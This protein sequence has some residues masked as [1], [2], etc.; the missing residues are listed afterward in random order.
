M[1]NIVI[2]MVVG[3]VLGLVL[4]ATVIAP[5][6]EQQQAATAESE[7]PPAEPRDAAAEA[8]RRLLTNP[9]SEPAVRL[10]MASAFA[11]GTPIIGTLAKRVETETWRISGGDVEITFHEPGALVPVREMFNAVAAGSVDAAFSSP[12]FWVGDVPALALFAAVP[13]GPGT[14]EYLAWFYFGGGR[15]LFEDI[16]HERGVHGLICGASAP[17]ASGWFRREIKSLNDFK[18]LRM[19]VFGLAAK[20][21]ARLGVET[22]LLTE[23]DIFVALESGDIDA[24][25][26][27]L[28]V[29]D[30]KLGFQA[31]ARHYY[32]PGWHQP[33]SLFELIVNREKWKAL[34]ST[35]KAQIEAMCGDNV[36]HGLAESEATQFAALKTLYSEGVQLHRWPTGILE[37]LEKIWTDVAN[38]EAGADTGFRRVWRSLKTF[39]ADYA[40]W[41][42]LSRL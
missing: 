7:A 37:A 24:A 26:Y 29:V 33:A 35:Q 2:G 9:I 40:I 12:G 6:M 13:F 3:A 23:G 14:E 28:P 21:L 38:E 10:K 36:R 17:E 22:R 5:R 15:E 34:S 27:S 1:R 30:L 11:S 31:L 4:G 42:E 39:R 8:A 19:R 25:E 41:R 20:V 32:F 18:G 16:Y